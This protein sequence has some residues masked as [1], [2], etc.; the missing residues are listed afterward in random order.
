MAVAKLKFLDKDEEDLIH[1]QSIECL[2]TLGVKIKSEKILKMLDE[3]GADIDYKAQIAKITEGMVKDALKTV[4]KEMTLHARDP[5]H[6]MKIP[7]SSFPFCATTGLGVYIR[8]I[9][10]GKKR[11]S[12]RKDIADFIRLADALDA[13]DYV[14]TSLTATEVPQLTHGLHELWTAFQNT[15]KH[16][17][18]VEILNAEDA[19]K[20][21]ELGALIAG[22]RE[23]LR[24]KPNFSVIHCSIAP[25]MFEHEAAEAMV[26][27]VK[28]GVPVA[29]MTMSLSGGTAPVTIAGTIVNGNSENLASLVINQTAAPGA[30]EIYCS[31][32]APVNMRTGIIDYMTVNQPLIATGLAQMAKRYGLP[33][34]TGDWGVN[35]TPEP[36]VPH[37]FSEVMGVS[38]STMSGTDLQS[39]IGGLDAVKGG[40]LEQEVIEAYIWENVRKF[41]TPFEISSVTAALNVIKEVG[42]GNT[43]LGH[44]HT[45]KNFRKEIVLRDPEKGRFESTNSTA[46]A[47]EARQ[48]A[49]KVLA[50]HEVPP[51]DKEILQK[52]N[53]IIRNWEKENGF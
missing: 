41:M 29:T 28:A 47:E 40:A 10:T 3:A 2:E 14:W 25:L 4:P 13:V 35:D 11:D 32:S 26:E 20:Q 49:L 24:K 45:A 17:Q 21:I 19:K 46:M 12:T 15:T 18:G 37:T 51:L 36:G 53:D 34:M 38:L 50:E 48:I 42:H 44:I 33:C 43:F 6:N 1:Q 52:G 7:V 16:V 31:S 27:F 9:K 23:E 30:P 8:D 39:G 5:M 22:G